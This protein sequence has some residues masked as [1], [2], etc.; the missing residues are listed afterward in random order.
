M[1]SKELRVGLEAWLKHQ[2]QL[3]AVEKQEE[4]QQSNNQLNELSAKVSLLFNTL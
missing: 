4:V 2:R 3:L 1:D